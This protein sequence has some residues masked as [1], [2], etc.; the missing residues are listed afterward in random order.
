[1]INTLLKTYRHRGLLQ[2]VNQI[3]VV[4]EGEQNGVPQSRFTPTRKSPTYKKT[5]RHKGNLFGE[6]PILIHTKP[7]GQVAPYIKTKAGKRGFVEKDFKVASTL[8]LK[9]KDCALGKYKALGS[10]FAQ[11]FSPTMEFFPP[12][13]DVDQLEKVVFLSP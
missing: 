5:N 8:L 11:P 7:D 3:N 1:M 12:I 2:K 9:R 4:V 13:D 6:C 10:R